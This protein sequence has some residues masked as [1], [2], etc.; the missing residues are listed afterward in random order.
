M[1][2]QIILFTLMSCVALSWSQ[3]DLVKE[4][5]ELNSARADLED[6]RKQRDQ[7]VAQR[8]QDRQKHNQER[9]KNN[10]V[11]RDLKEKVDV[12][13]TERARLFDELRAVRGD[14]AQ[15]KNITEQARNEFLLLSAQHD[16]LDVL[17]RQID[18]GIPFAVPE[19]LQN[20]NKL[21]KRMDLSRDNPGLIAGELLRETLAQLRFTRQVEWDEGDL[22]FPGAETVRGQRLRLG[23]VGAVQFEPT[24]G[25]AAL[26][27]ATAG[28]KGRI[29]AWQDK[30][31]EN[32]QTLIGKA[33]HEIKDSSVVY[34]PV[35]V[36]LSTFL[37]DEMA[38]QEELTPQMQLQRFMKDGGIL[39]YPIALLFVLAL[40][41]TVE[42][43]LYVSAKG[44]RFKGQMR[45]V[46][47]LLEQGDVADAQ[48]YAAKMKGLI[49][50]VAK[51]VTANAHTSREFTEQRLEELFTRAVPRLE[52]RLNVIAIFGSSA[53]LL[54]LLGTVMGM[55]QLFEVITLYGTSDPKLL[56]GG[57]SV[58]LITTQAGLIVAIPVQL[59]H[60]WV[61][62]RVEAL[63]V[64][65]ESFALRL[66]N[67]IWVHQDD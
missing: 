22:Y 62:N 25:R 49:G 65:M 36:L 48:Q 3:V 10:E 43:M 18:L 17:S 39:M 42:R 27:L 15:A 58:A 60:T 7:V 45:K 31:S 2:L 9:E 16:R 4:Q 44:V 19:R 34:L 29:F 66:L 14:V 46:Q 59:L 41:F 64:R 6:A 30:L 8:W 23:S 13:A 40:I 21:R 47:A 12:L 26:M 51:I 32:Y 5:A 24:Q 63:V 52:K 67:T 35:D 11:L 50:Q 37:S 1:R 61:A 55:I 28:D 53:P 38:S 20:L 56:A 57:I 54:G 33:F